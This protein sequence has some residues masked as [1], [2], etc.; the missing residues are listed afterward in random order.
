MDLHTFLGNYNLKLPTSFTLPVSQKRIIIHTDLLSSN[1]T[2]TG[3]TLDII[4]KGDKQ[5]IKLLRVRQHFLEQK[6]KSLFEF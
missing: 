1:T 4:S 6:C 2:E 3:Y 5:T